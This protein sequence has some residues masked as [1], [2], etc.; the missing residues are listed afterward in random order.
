PWARS[1][2]AKSVT[3]DRT[4]VT[5]LGRRVSSSLVQPTG[6]IV[7]RSFSRADGALQVV[8]AAE[9]TAA[10]PPEIADLPAFAGRL[11]DDPDA[12]GPPGF[13][14]LPYSLQR[15]SE[16]GSSSVMGAEDSA[17][18][19]LSA[20]VRLW[21]ELRGRLYAAARA[22]EF[23]YLVPGRPRGQVHRYGG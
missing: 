15:A 8:A 11:E 17:G 20:I 3:G 12:V 19:L 4:W 7:E 16:T 21:P 10:H 9:V 18:A 1:G 14:E 6:E 13:Q 23:S 2:D 5:D 22:P